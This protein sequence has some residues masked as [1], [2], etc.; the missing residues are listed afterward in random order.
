MNDNDY[1]GGAGR[2]NNILWDM[3][4]DLRNAAANSSAKSADNSAN[5]TENQKLYVYAWCLPYLSAENCSGC[6]SDAIAEVLTSC[7][8]GKSGGT[9]LYPSCGIRFELYPFHK[10]HDSISWVQPSPTSPRSLSPLG[11]QTTITIFEIIVPTIVLMV[12]LVLGYCCFLYR[13][14]RKS[15]HDFEKCKLEHDFVNL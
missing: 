6:P 1:V 11:K 13:K 5:L 10:I 7:C 12:I 4:N 15:K 9:I 8:R 3:L 2:F 14:G